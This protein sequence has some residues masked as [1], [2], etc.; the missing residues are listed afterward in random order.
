MGAKKRAQ[1][2]TLLYRKYALPI[3]H[4]YLKRGMRPEQA[5]DLLQ[6]VFVLVVR[7]IDGYKGDGAFSAWIWTIARNTLISEYRKSNNK[8]DH[9][10]LDD[11]LDAGA[12]ATQAINLV[13]EEY[14]KCVRDAFQDFSKEHQ[15]RAHALSLSVFHGWN[16]EELSG[17]LGRTR[18]ATREFLSQSRK[19][20]KPF[21]VRCY[22]LLKP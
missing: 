2:I 11:I 17:F 19:K 1:G 14:K 9:D 20:I 18:G 3:K 10:N 4:Y 8:I 6:E 22:E 5:E 15:D 7:K 16:I 12:H 21:L 13:E